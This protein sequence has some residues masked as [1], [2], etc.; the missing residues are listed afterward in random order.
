MEVDEMNGIITETASSDVFISS[1]SGKVSV[2]PA[3]DVPVMSNDG[4]MVDDGMGWSEDGMMDP[5]MGGTLEPVKDPILSSWLFVGG[6]SA[7]TLA[8]SIVLG[9]LLAKKRIKKGF[10]IYEI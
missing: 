10:D 2:M 8:I 5:G 3:V 9:I 4:Y 6:I 7:L 1:S